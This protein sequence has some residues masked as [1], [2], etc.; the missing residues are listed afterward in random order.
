MARW[1]QGRTELELGLA[2]PRASLFHLFRILL[3]S[4]PDAPEMVPA[5][6]QS[7]VLNDELRCYRCA[8]V[9]SQWG[10]AIKFFIGKCADG[11]SRIT[12]VLAQEFQRNGLRH[13]GHF[14]GVPG[15]QISHSI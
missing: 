5:V 9:Q 2:H 6:T 8:V 4:R 12:A 7:V 1:D 14:A 11:S 15:V 13:S 10:G 3:Q